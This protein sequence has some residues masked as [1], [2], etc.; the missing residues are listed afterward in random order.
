MH[1]AARIVSDP[2]APCAEGDAATKRTCRDRSDHLAAN[3]IDLRDTPFFRACH[4]ERSAAE[5]ERSRSNTDRNGLDLA[6]RLRVDP[7]HGAVTRVRDP[8]R[9]CPDRDPAGVT[10]D[11]DPLGGTRPGIDAR[12]GAVQRIGC[13]D[14]PFPGGDARRPVADRDIGHEPI[15]PTSIAATEF[16]EAAPSPAPSPSVSSMT[17][18]APAANRRRAAPAAIKTPLRRT[19]PGV[20]A[21]CA[22]GSSRGSCRRIPRSSS[23]S[24]GPGSSPSSSVSSLRVSRYASSASVW[25]PERYRASMSWARRRSRTGCRRTSASTSG[26]RSA[27]RP[28]ARSA[29]ILSSRAARCSSS[30]ER[31]RRARTARTRSLKVAARA[32]RECG[33]KGLRCAFGV[34]CGE[35]LSTLTEQALE[36]V[37]VE[38]SWIEQQH[39]PTT[40]RLSRPSPSVLRS[41]ET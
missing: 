2:D 23:C 26:T 6:V 32:R 27:W 11:V 30:S 29:S 3:G 21:V 22:G 4:P 40:T 33:P 18:A 8:D 1:G 24:S 20:A 15:D 39:V 37:E 25:R 31:S 16:A 41:C 9:A 12:D 7:R 34:A 10:P 17:A 14:R 38:F 36:T 35:E 28:R 19:R 13:P 5:G